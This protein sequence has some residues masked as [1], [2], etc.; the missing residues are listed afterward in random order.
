MNDY[1]KLAD[2]LYPNVKYDIEYFEKKR[3]DAIKKHVLTLGR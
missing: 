2:L 3:Y 1:E